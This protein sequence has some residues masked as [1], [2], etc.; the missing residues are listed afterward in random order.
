MPYADDILIRSFLQVTAGAAGIVLAQLLALPL[1]AAAEAEQGLA[2]WY[3]PYY[4]GRITANG[5]VFNQEAPTAAHRTLPF[6]TYVRVV[7]TANG[8]S[9]VV[10]IND[11]GPFIGGRV[12]DLSKAAARQVGALQPG[13]V[14]V[15]L[16]ILPPQL[17]N[18]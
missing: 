6:G 5:E 11:R 1:P 9:T 2:S 4:H 3:G 8:L 16:Q 10:R 18:D 14:P 15:V 17:A 13:I 12:I 7:N